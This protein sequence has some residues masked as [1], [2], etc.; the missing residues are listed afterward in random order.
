MSEV[1]AMLDGYATI[2][3]KFRNPPNAVADQGIDLK[4]RFAAL[5]TILPK[6]EPAKKTAPEIPQ[7][8]CH[9]PIFDIR[10]MF[11]LGKEFHPAK[12]PTIPAIQRAVCREFDVELIDLV[13]SRR[14]AAVTLPRQIAMWLCRHLTTSSSPAIGRHFGGR[15][16]TTCLHAFKKIDRLREADKDVD[17]MVRKLEYELKPKVS[18]HG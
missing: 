15:D 9:G 10:S 5:P 11:L 7:P 12:Q 8:W 16:H 6:P 14:T 1:S 17:A 2:R 13:S 4:R 18:I 3:R